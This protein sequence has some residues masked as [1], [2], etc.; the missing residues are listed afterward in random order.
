MDRRRKSEQTDQFAIVAVV[1]R[2]SNLDL[3]RHFV[4][5]EKIAVDKNQEEEKSQA[6]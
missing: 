3:F 6:E 1:K 2:A 4:F 5:M